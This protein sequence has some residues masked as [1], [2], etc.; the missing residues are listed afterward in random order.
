MF[1]ILVKHTKRTRRSS[2][3]KC[4]S[5]QKFAPSTQV[6]STIRWRRNQVKTSR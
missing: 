4:G 1:K 6:W 3:W 2:Q 5:R